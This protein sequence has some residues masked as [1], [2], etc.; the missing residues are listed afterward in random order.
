MKRDASHGNRV[1]A[2]LSPGCEG[3]VHQLCGFFGVVIEQLVKITHAVKHQLI[4]VLAFDFQILLHHGCVRS[5]NIV[6]THW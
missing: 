2:G 1:A 3:N 5:F 4:R 6:C